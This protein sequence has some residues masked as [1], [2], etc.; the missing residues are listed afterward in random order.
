MARRT[1]SQAFEGTVKEFL[2][3]EFQDFDMNLFQV[4]ERGVNKEGLPVF[5]TSYN[6]QRLTLN[7]TSGRKWLQVKWRIQASM[8]DK[9]DPNKLKVSLAVG[10]EVAATI[11]T[12]EDAVKSVVLP[13]LKTVML[14]VFAG[15][16]H[17][18]HSAI[19]D[20]VFTPKIT[21]DAKNIASVTQF[22]VRPFQKDVVNVAG[23]DQLLPLL[24][25]NSGFMG[26]KARAAVS[27]DSIWILK[28]LGSDP[29]T[30]GIFW[31]IHHIM[32]DLPEQV[33]WV[34]PDVFA[35]ASWDDDEE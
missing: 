9:E 25:E 11:Q 2:I 17:N 30:A 28:G 23:K 33:R 14:P 19:R 31:K 8:Y 32:V 13:K 1:A 10:D 3:T 22:K 20:N 29:S 35:N 12:I 34:V 5:V 26:A 6:Q 27:P 18:W 21:L 4:K 24:N 15:G 7:L 16:D